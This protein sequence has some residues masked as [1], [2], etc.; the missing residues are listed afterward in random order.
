MVPLD[1]K[2][3]V[4][5]FRRGQTVVYPTETLYALGVNALDKL[6]VSRLREIKNRPKEKVFPVIVSDIRQA[7]EF[8]VFSNLERLVVGRFWPGPLSLV[9]LSKSRSLTKALG[10]RFVAVR[11]SFNP[12]ARK[13]TELM[14]S[15]L[16]S[17]S[18]N[19]SGRQGCFSITCVERQFKGRP[20]K[21]YG[22]INVGK[23]RRSY[24]STVVMFKGGKVQII[25][26]GVVTEKDIYSVTS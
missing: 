7:E 16:V 23:L 22:F 6:A 12:I 3:A 25:R 8:F 10:S 15:P 18:A 13:L 26:P 11:V 9:L 20:L 1:V 4:K 24:P 21:P 19:L 14:G 2:D 5:I 17:T